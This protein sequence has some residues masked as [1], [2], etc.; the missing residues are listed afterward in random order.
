MLR[1][2]S[3]GAITAAPAAP[4]GEL[5]V[6]AAPAEAP[7]WLRRRVEPAAEAPAPIRPSSALAAADRWSDAALTPARREALRTGS[8]THVLLQYLPD[9]PAEGRL[10]AAQAFLEARAADLDLA[11]RGGLIDGALRVIDAPELAVLFGPQSRAE[12][13][14]AGRVGL[15]RGG[16]IDV[17]G[18]IDRIG[19]ATDEALIADFK[20]GVPCAPADVPQSYLAQM[21]LYRAALAPLWPGRRLR[22]LLVWTAEPSVVTLDD[23]ASRRGAGG[24][25]GCVRRPSRRT[26]RQSRL[27]ARLDATAPA[28]YF[29]DETLR[30][31]PGATIFQRGAMS[32]VKVTDASFKA[33][34]VGAA[35]PVVV[36]F[37]AEWCGPCKMI[38]PALEEIAAELKGQVTIAK[39]NVDENPGVAGAYGIRSIPT[40]LLFKDGKQAS[41]KVGAAPKGELK[42]WISE[43]I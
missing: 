31:L 9:L 1:L 42:R 17:V 19:V 4:E 27:S 5:S 7:D 35:G 38:G 8:L 40:L 2:V 33:D 25:R 6:A 12:V 23:D 15:P 30:D 29:R 24:D 13:A 20:T 32:T 16:S 21:A 14:V 37:W 39:L 28:S 11:T 41:I 3:A 18:R 26:G 22:M 43:A 34:V 36:D 10:R